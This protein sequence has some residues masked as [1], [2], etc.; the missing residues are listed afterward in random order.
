MQEGSANG[1]CLH[2]P[3]TL[4]HSWVWIWGDLKDQAALRIPVL[5]WTGDS[6]LKSFCLSEPSG[7]SHMDVKSP[8][9]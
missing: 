3:V 5:D 6:S 4:T 2:Q 7:L 9:Q 1:T 8:G